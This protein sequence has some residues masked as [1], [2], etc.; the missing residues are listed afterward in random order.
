MVLKQT[1][2]NVFL[3]IV[4]AA[5]LLACGQNTSES[6]PASSLKVGVVLGVGGENDKSFNEYTLKG[7]RQAA[8]EAG[9]NFEYI[10][11]DSLEDY[12]RNVNTMAGKTDLVIT[13]GYLFTEVTAKAAR[14]N[15]NVHFVIVDVPYFPGQGC[16]ETVDDCYSEE[17]GLTN[18]TSLVFAEDEMGYLAGVLAACMSK[19]GTIASVSGMEIPPVIRLVTSY[20]NGAKSVN[21]DIVVLNQYVPNFD[22]SPTGKLVGQDFINRGADVIAGFGGNT[23]NGGLLAAHQA[24]KMAIGVDVDQY[25]T[26][27]EVQTSLLSST[28]KFIDVA[29]A[30]VVNQFAAGQLPAGIQ[31]KTLSTGGVGLT[32]YHD[33]ENEIMTAGCDEK[34]QVAIEAIKADPTLT[35]VQ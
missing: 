6:T 26:Y 20:Q 35:G 1:T 30:D 2:I 5:W 18:V 21:P 14:N 17:G 15:P 13:P 31:A 3:L 16:P 24:G 25:Y 19:T 29:V 12:E 34:I 27:P 11:T 9:L 8:Q 4:M 28:A 7:A 23:G 10:T 32:S 22:D 33:W